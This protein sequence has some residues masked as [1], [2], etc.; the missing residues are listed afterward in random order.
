VDSF[1]PGFGNGPTQSY[2]GRQDS[3]M[4][5]LHMHGASG[6]AADVVSPV[7]EGTNTLPS[8]GLGSQS[9]QARR[10][11][12]DGEDDDRYEATPKK[13]RHVFRY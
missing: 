8:G 11:D 10:Y 4:D 1:H 5:N 7:S 2:L 3:A 9:E 6:A 13:D 12:V